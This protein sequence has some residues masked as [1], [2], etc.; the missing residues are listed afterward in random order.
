MRHHSSYSNYTCWSIF[1]NAVGFGFKHVAMNKYGFLPR[2]QSLCQAFQ[3]DMRT[4]TRNHQLPFLHGIARKMRVTFLPL[5][6][7][8]STC[9]DKNIAHTC[10]V[11]PPSINGIPS[12]TFAKK[13]YAQ[14][15]WFAH[16]QNSI[17]THDF[18]TSSKKR[19]EIVL[20]KLSMA[21]WLTREAYRY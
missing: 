20:T 5:S 8:V 17:K 1:L 6:L 12:E 10:G 2:A 9:F 13:C 15:P 4:S 7:T 11:I 18:V 3:S 21:L 19:D 14:T 16:E